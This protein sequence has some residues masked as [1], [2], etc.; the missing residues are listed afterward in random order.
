M[1]Q[2]LLPEARQIE[3]GQILIVASAGDAAPSDA[4]RLEAT[5]MKKR[6]VTVRTFVNMTGSFGLEVLPRRIPPRRQRR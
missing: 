3:S 1:S 4:A 5:L 2:Q 6:A